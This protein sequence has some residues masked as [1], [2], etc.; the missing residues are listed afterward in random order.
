MSGVH[1]KIRV[2]GDCLKREGGAW[3][4]CRFK[5]GLGKKEGSVF[6]RVSRYSNA[7]YGGIAIK[8]L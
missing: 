6:L 8:K 1:G 2:R 4:V 3:T 5:K 7:H